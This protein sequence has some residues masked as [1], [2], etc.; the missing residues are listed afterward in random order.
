MK[1]DHQETN[2]MTLELIYEQMLLEGQ[3]QPKP[4][5]QEAY[6]RL[7]AINDKAGIRDFTD[8]LLQW[9][10]SALKQTGEDISL[11]KTNHIRD[12]LSILNKS[13]SNGTL[14]PGTEVSVETPKGLQ[15]K[16]ISNPRNF[17]KFD[18]FE[19]A[20]RNYLN[21]QTASEGEQYLQQTDLSKAQIALYKATPDLVVWAT[22]GYEDTL[23]FIRVLWPKMQGT[24]NL[25]AYGASAYQNDLCPYCTSGKS[26][27]I[28]YSS[29][30]NY[31]Q[32]WFLKN[33]GTEL[34]DYYG[35]G[36]ETL[37]AMLDSNGDLLNK[38][39]VEFSKY[40]Q[41]PY[42]SFVPLVKEIYLRHKK[43][44]DKGKDSVFNVLNAPSAEELEQVKL[45][46]F[47]NLK[48]KTDKNGVYHGDIKVPKYITSL[49]G[50]PK[51]VSGDFYCNGNQLTSLQGA[52]Q[53]VGLGFYCNNNKLTSLEGAPQ[54]VG[55]DFSCSSNQLT[56]L[57]GIPQNISGDLFVSNN[58]LQSLD[59]APQKVS[60]DFYCNDNRLTSLK[61]APQKIGGDFR[62]NGNGQLTSLE[63]A[64][65]TIGR[66]FYC[67]SNDL[68]TSLKGA[69]RK[70]DGD[71]YCNGSKLI[72]LE[73]AP[74]TVGRDFNCSRN[75]LTS[76]KGA[77]QKVGGNFNCS[78]NKLTSLKGA[79]Q[80]V[81]GEFS[82]KNNPIRFTEIDLRNAQKESRRK[83]PLKESVYKMNF[84]K[85]VDELF[86]S[87][88]KTKKIN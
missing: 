82:C 47:N 57:E 24:S 25:G 71:F 75:Q 27:W 78:D 21:Q 60:G 70:V 56:S 63:G 69:P 6:D 67:S 41:H 54:K 33:I 66:D 86:I 84:N 14:K 31:T 44:M 40:T 64:P 48:K 30:K 83:K 37:Y 35:K 19:D 53:S 62:C 43:E 85:L 88:Q 49:V 26:H 76:L 2:R 58:Q 61:G 11:D 28:E 36:K 52:P 38:Y 87:N 13:L 42:P 39:D 81:G 73:G 65:Q 4:E 5:E 1:F 79:P 20:L 12:T 45:E 15:K 7:V 3:L 74:R 34:K 23:A 17:F 59:G 68:L 46:F 8:A 22:K 32:Y 10:R 29:G 55:E 51:K 50:M 9:Y 72:S 18:A 77:P 16:D 80:Y